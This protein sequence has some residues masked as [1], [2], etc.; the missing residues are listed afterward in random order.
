MW[1]WS[2][3][4][5]ADVLIIYLLGVVV[6]AMR[7]PRTVSVFTAVTSVLAF[8][9]LFIPPPFVF[10]L[11]DI[12]SALTCGGMLVV[13]LVISGLTHRLREAESLARA[14]EARTSIL[15]ALSRELAEAAD[16]RRLAAIAVSHV[17]RL[18]GCP[19]AVLA[20]G[21]PGEWIVVASSG[22]FEL[23]TAERSGV[24]AA[25]EGRDEARSPASHGGVGAPSLTLL[26]L[27]GTRGLVGLLA[28]RAGGS[29]R[30]SAG[31]DE[32]E[33]LHVCARQAALAMERAELATEAASAHVA[34]ETERARGAL[35]SSLSHDLRTPLA[36]I[37]G[38]GTSLVDYGAELD[39]AA[40]RDLARTVVEEGER[41]HRLLTNVLGLTRLEGGVMQVKKTPQA[42]EEILDA[43]LRRVG[44]RLSDRGVRM[45]VPL[46]VPLVP[47]D[48]V[49]IE[50]LFINVI[51]NAL[52]YTPAGSP[53]EVEVSFDGAEVSVGI[54]D[55]G[56]GVAVGEEG[57]IFEKFYRSAASDP[58]DG[59]IGLGLFICQA[60]AEAH[61]GRISGK[62]RKQGGLIVTLV[63]PRAGDPT[64]AERT[65]YDAARDGGSP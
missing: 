34:V 33:L 13:A 47:L 62:N 59:G 24:A 49:L 7:F 19:A 31:A 55:R 57:R 1:A 9:F 15:Y 40:Q 41:L 65:L 54:A 53:I 21:A 16:V 25:W 12:K 29:G 42:I 46:D 2:R 22:P 52:R 35:L 58:R 23:D 30:P 27:P 5:L 45:N 48:A 61:G 50:Q 8:D 32:R 64:A 28:L 17:E 36:A 20:P 11:P 51:E 56:P 38:A 4:Q 26:P 6:V 3:L 39:D 14:R 43:A 60:I 18:A 63:M 44:A 10:S 37:V